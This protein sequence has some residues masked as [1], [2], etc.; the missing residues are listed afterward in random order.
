MNFR[1]IVTECITALGASDTSQERDDEVVFSNTRIRVRVVYNIKSREIDIRF[2][3]K[4]Q[5][6][7]ELSF[8]DLIQVQC[9]DAFHYSC[10]F[11]V[12]D[13]LTA[14]N[15]LIAVNKALLGALSWIARGDVAE[16][17]RVKG[18]FE[19]AVKF[20]FNEKALREIFAQLN[21]LWESKA[22]DSFIVLANSANT[23]DSIN[24]KRLEYA[25]KQNKNKQG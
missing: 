18:Q 3:L 15:Y 4:S 1:L 24:L 25:K 23:L 20:A 10:P 13:M 17:S 2:S 9:L 5:E 21:T 8:S 7:D 14:R 11:N 12:S 19:L 22:F 16:F 6:L